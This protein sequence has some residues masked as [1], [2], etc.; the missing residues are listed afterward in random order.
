MLILGLGNPIRGDDGVGI[1]AAR[2]LKKHPLPEGVEVKEA[3]EAGLRL[4][5]LI[6][7]YDEVLIVDALPSR[8]EGKV[9]E[10]EPSEW[11]N[12][13]Q[14]PSP[15]Y[16]GLPQVLEWGKRMG[17]RLPRRLK[18]VGVG[19]RP[20]QPFREGLSA[21]VEASLPQVVK[22]LREEAER[23]ARGGK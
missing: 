9:Y 13:G 6:E 1:R 8:E 23:W 4:L 22:K 10:I 19:I 7:G 5:D 15:H 17:L 18:I 21:K 3:E 2:E 11:T 20:L 16:F 12:A 14:G